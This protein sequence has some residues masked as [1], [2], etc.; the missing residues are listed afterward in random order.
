[1]KSE[2]NRSH[3]KLIAKLCIAGLLLFFIFWKVDL[4]RVIGEIGAVPAPALLLASVLNLATVGLATFK[5]LIIT[6]REFRYGQLMKLNLIGCF[7]GMILPGQV[8]GEAAKALLISR[9][10][11]RKVELALSVIVDKI[12]GLMGLLLLGTFGVFLGHAELPREIV[13]V[14][15]SS[16]VALAGLLMGGRISAVVVTFRRILSLQVM[17]KFGPAGQMG[18]SVLDGWSAYSRSLP[19]ILLVIGIG[20]LCQV[21]SVWTVLPLSWSLELRIAFWDWAWVL[22]ILSTVV[23]LPVTVGGLG[24]REGTLV[25]LLSILGVS[26]EKALSLSFLIFFFQLI[27]A[28]LGGLLVLRSK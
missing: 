22:A 28:S 15:F 1:M 4:S 19:K 6:D 17:Q 26:P 14:L 5:W 20:V 24:L 23:L 16:T 11:E 27:L 7:Y 3:F 21:L 13:I 2:S 9:G 18:S 25:G 10:R 12:T 8:A